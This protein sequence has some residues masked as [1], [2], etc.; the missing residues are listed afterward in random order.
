MEQVVLVLGNYLADNIFWQ[1]EILFLR[2]KLES[3]QNT[4]EIF[5][6]TITIKS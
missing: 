6:I 3:K 2:R 4:I 5:Y 1:E